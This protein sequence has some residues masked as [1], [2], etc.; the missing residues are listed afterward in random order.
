MEDHKNGGAPGDRVLVTGG[1]GFL[2]RAI[3]ERLVKRG[4]PVRSFSRNPY[5]ELEALGVEQIQGDLRDPWAVDRAVN[6]MD[7]VFHTAAK[8]G[9]WGAYREY[10]QTN[11]IGTQNVIH[12]CRQ[13]GIRQLVYTSSPSVVFSGKD[14]QGVDES[15]PYPKRYHAPYPKTK[16]MAEKAVVAA[17]DTM[18]TIVL[19]PHLIWGPRDNHLVPRIIQRAGKLRRVGRGKNQV[20]TIYIDNAADAHLL[21]AEALAADPAL[22]GRVYFISQ[23][24]PV[25]LWEMVDAILDA[26]GLPPVRKTVPRSVAWIAGALLEAAYAALR[27]REEPPMTRFVASELATDHWFNIDAARRDFGYTPEVST[28]EGL[29]RLREWLQEQ[30]P[31]ATAE[32]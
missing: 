2:G 13:W 4:N 17:A 22:S 14:M 25:D 27:I 12:S 6:G 24:T 30:T 3:V 1:G 16:S 8:A 29:R 21:A 9:V 31:A 15:T 7:V 32:A 10:F 23:G 28:E 19:R 20:D 5:P 11:Y 26:A 18:G